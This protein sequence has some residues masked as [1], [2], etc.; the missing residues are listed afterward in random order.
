M[1]NS[2]FA[3]RAA[4]GHQAR[5]KA[6]PGHSRK[7]LPQEAVSPRNRHEFLPV[8]VRRKLAGEEMRPL[9]PSALPRDAHAEREREDDPTRGIAPRLLPGRVPRTVPPG[10]APQHAR[11]DAAR[12]SPNPRQPR[13]AQLIAPS[14]ANRTVG[15][16]RSFARS[17]RFRF[18]M[19]NFRLPPQSRPSPPGGAMTI[20]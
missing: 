14:A 20:G 16:S 19:L 2:C 13:T 9:H 17:G 1:P 15:R 10:R 18:I 12:A 6:R 7:E 11:E 3:P 8:P 5:T 4:P